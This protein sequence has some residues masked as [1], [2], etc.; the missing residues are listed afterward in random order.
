MPALGE[1][2]TF[3]NLGKVLK[4]MVNGPILESYTPVWVFSLDKTF[5]VHPANLLEDPPEDLER[6]C[7]D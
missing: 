6:N 7:S 2:V 3:R 5:Y 4:G 1:E